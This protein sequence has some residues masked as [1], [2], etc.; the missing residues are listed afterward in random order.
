MKQHIK[1]KEFHYKMENIS[2]ITTGK[3]AK[4]EILKFAVI[5]FFT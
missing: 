2:F 4:I 1:T 3:N 5:Y